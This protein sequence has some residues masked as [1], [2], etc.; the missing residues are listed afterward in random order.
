MS[1]PLLTLRAIFRLLRVGLHLG[2]GTATVLCVYPFAPRTWRL[3]LKRRWSR[4]LLAIFGIRLRVE[5]MHAARMRVANHISWLDI[6][7]INAVVPSAF[8]S[9]DDVRGWPLIGWLST[10]IET[11]FIQRGSHRAAHEAA[12]HIAGLLEASV[13]VV[14]FPEGTTSPGHQVLPFHGALLQGA[15][16]AQAPVQPM[17]IRYQD[18]RGRLSE[19]PAYCGATGL[20]ESI[21]RVACTD[22]L[23][24]LLCLLPA[25]DTRP[26]ERRT[27]AATLHEHIVT[28]LDGVGWPPLHGAV[29]TDTSSPAEWES[30]VS[31]DSRLISS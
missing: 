27:L 6:F 22:Q 4:Q 30:V 25:V 26:H 5:G 24:V 3:A 16:A 1:N 23:T 2:W 10:H 19:A 18:R 8:V 7:V 31:S 14:A 29:T 9:K 13:D 21:W 11:Y 12:R 28:R 17:A 20:G 15:I